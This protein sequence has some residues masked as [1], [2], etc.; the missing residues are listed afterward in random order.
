MGR[1]WRIGRRWFPMY[2]SALLS[3][4]G[5]L[6]T[7]ATVVVAFVIWALI[8][9]L[10]KA[11]EQAVETLIPLLAGGGVTVIVIALVQWGKARRAI[12]AEDNEARY[13]GSVQDDL[14]KT[15]TNWLR[16]RIASPEL[17]IAEAYLFGS[18]THADYPTTDVDMVVLYTEMPINAYKNKA[19]ALG[20]LGSTFGKTFSLPL[21]LQKFLSSERSAFED[22]VGKQEEPIRLK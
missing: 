20:P 10:P 21:H 8:A 9:G 19:S 18:V 1:Q 5:A 12:Q 16:H 7:G 22:F 4:L 2:R 3:R 11:W 13:M 17:G 6:A 14:V 15:L